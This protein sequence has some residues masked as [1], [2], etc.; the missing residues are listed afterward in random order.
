MDS[1]VSGATSFVKW[2]FQWRV[3]GE[4]LVRGKVESDEELW[5]GHQEEGND[6]NVNK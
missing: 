5:W 2:D 6:Q 3:E 1:L 4:H